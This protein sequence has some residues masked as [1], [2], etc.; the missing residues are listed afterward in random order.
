MV[1]IIINVTNKQKEKAY[2]N[3]KYFHKARNVRRFATIERGFDFYM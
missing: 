2:K 1:N 3:A